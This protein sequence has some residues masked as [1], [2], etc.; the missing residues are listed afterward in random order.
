MLRML[1]VLLRIVLS[2]KC[3][4]INN[5]KDVNGSMYLAHAN[6]KLEESCLD[7]LAIVDQLLL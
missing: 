7:F 1:P 4:G 3:L 6:S 5:V 2:L